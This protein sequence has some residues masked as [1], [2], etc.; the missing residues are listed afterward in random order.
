MF[1]YLLL[2]LFAVILTALA[3]ILL[4]K[5]MMQVGELEFSMASAWPMIRT[6]AFNP[7]VIL[8]LA[9]F[10]ISV[11]AWLVVLARV[12]V[13]FA[14][15]FTSIGYIVTAGAG[16]YLFN[17][18]LGPYRIAGILLICLGVILVAKS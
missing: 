17:E 1:K 15:P 11:L 6:V 16:Y 18:S 3:Q 13:S 5:G 4:K 12:D 7:Y 2:I 8:G 14:Y 9:C 10:A